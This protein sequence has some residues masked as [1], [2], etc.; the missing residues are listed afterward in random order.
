MNRSYV[1]K[2]LRN[3]HFNPVISPWSIKKQAQLIVYAFPG[4]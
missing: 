4:K 3:N 1:G 2:A